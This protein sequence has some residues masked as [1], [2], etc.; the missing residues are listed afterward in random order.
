MLF[1]HEYSVKKIHE[2]NSMKKVIFYTVVI[3]EFYVILLTLSIL[4]FLI[5]KHIILNIFSLL[6]FRKT[7]LFFDI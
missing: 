6:L 7:F 5:V 3:I 2:D 4:S 1:V